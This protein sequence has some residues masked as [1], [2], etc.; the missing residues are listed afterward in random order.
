MK[1]NCLNPLSAA[2]LDFW[3]C[4]AMVINLCLCC[5]E[6][7]VLK[8]SIVE[9]MGTWIVLFWNPTNI[10]I[11]YNEQ[12]NWANVNLYLR[13]CQDVWV[14]CLLSYTHL[15]RNNGGCFLLG[16]YRQ[17]EWHLEQLVGPSTLSW[18]I[19]SHMSPLSVYTK[20]FHRCFK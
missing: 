6:S 8:R 16:Y 18:R 1:Q 9:Y 2:K 10:Y 14:R 20:F 15:T 7:L 5:K 3:R 4:L 11:L 19:I 13:S 17:H 12:Y